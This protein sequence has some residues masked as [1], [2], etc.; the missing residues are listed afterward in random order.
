MQLEKTF[1]DVNDRTYEGWVFGAPFCICKY[2]ND[3]KYR[4]GD[5]EANT[6][7][8]RTANAKDTHKRT[9][10]SNKYFELYD[11]DQVTA[12]RDIV[13]DEELFNTYGD[14]YSFSSRSA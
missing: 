11:C 6:K 5:P 7:K 9:G 2:I 12:T 10:H 13:V 1:V 4:P 3:P 14:G 8:L